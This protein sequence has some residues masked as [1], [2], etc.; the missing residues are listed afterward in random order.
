[1]LADR[2]I[3]TD[4]TS[5]ED[6]EKNFTLKVPEHFHFAYDVV[7]EYARI[8]PDK[9]ALIWCDLKGHERT[10]TFGEISRMSNQAANVF[11]AHGLKKGDPVILML[12]RRWQFWVAAVGLLKLGCVLIPAT[13]QLQ[14]KD[15]V[16]RV[17]ASSARAILC[18]EEPEVREHV[19]ASAPECDT[20][21]AL[22][23]LGGMLSSYFVGSKTAQ[24]LGPVKLSVTGFGLLA[25]YCLVLPRLHTIWGMAI[26]Q[27]IGG[28][29]GTSTFS[30]IMSDAIAE[31][32]N[33]QRSTAMGFFQ[34]I[35]SIG[36]MAGPSL[37]GTMIDRLTMTPAFAV[38]GIICI[39]TAAGYPLLR[40]FI[41][42]PGK[43]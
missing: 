15:I 33:E 17:Q 10:F 13:A 5:Q 34:S 23:T 9:R 25:I 2:Y 21:T 20:L 26:L 41:N 24:K 11:K 32:P 38:V 7:D 37:M 36:I 19:L 12:K 14:K 4:L 40:R 22:F 31:V 8:S 39:V 35:Y 29:G 1:M 30:I 43:A 16:Y 42:K 6:F 28:C 3:R 27:F 18:V